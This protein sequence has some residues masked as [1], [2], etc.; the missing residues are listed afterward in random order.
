[1]NHRG[2]EDAEECGEKIKAFNRRERITK[3]ASVK[4][5]ELNGSFR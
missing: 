4:R 5:F 2:T 3:L 1:M